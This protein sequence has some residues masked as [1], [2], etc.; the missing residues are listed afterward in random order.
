MDHLIEHIEDDIE[1]TMRSFMEELQ[2]YKKYKECPSYNELKALVK[3]SN[4]LRGFIGWDKL[5]IRQLVKN[6]KQND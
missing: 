6:Y 4:V 3:A 2:S 1:F 5:T